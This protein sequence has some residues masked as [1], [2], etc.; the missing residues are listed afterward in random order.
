MCVGSRG[1]SGPQWEFVSGL[2]LVMGVEGGFGG[3]GDEGLLPTGEH[4]QGPLWSWA[5]ALEGHLAE[6]Y[7]R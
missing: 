2:R 5:L 1:V 3:P 4:V 7:Q 6:V